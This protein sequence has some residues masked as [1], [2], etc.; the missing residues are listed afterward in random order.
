M[1]LIKVRPAKVVTF[2]RARVE[3]KLQEKSVTQRFAQEREKMKTVENLEA[4][5]DE[6]EAE[7]TLLEW[8]AEEHHFTPKSPRWYIALALG[9][10]LAAG[11]SVFLGNILGAV[12]I[13]LVGGLIY[14]L[15]QHEPDEVRYR[16]MVDGVAIN[17][18]L[19]QFRNLAAFNI[20][21]QP[22]EVKTVLLR[23]QKMLS[24]LI[25]MEIGE[26]DPMK[27]RETLLEFLPEDLD[28][29]EPVTDTWARRLGF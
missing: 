27:I 7:A 24:P 11:A 6:V 13:A 8:R 1:A 9:V 5:A 12:A 21:Y 18:R 15:A 17:D 23:S 14:V 19:Y 26:A 4:V 22:G 20:V 10:T 29:Q 25:Q 2:Q 3:K 28:M 16:L